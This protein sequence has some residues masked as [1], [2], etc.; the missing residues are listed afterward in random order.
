L[1]SSKEASTSALEKSGQLLQDRAISVTVAKPEL[2][3]EGIPVLAAAT[4]KASPEGYTGGS[5]GT[6]EGGAAATEH[7]FISNLPF[8]VEEAD[9]RSFFKDVRLVHWLKDKRG[10]FKGRAILLFSSKEASTSALEK[11]G[12]LLQDRAISVTVA[13]PELLKEGIPVLT[14]GSSS[15]SG[16]KISRRPEGTTHQQRHITARPEGCNVI[17]VSGVSKHIED[18]HMEDLF[19][20]CGEISEIRWIFDRNTGNFKQ[21]GCVEFINE[22]SVDLAMA[23][24]GEY[25]LGNPI[26]INYAK[27]KGR[28]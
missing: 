3:K 17:F 9:V 18:K 20:D 5:N 6:D 7:I 4:S 10:K 24:A 21:C 13:K 27:P 22:D 25:V 23:K 19:K 8:T 14:D 11:S 28:R 16:K 15:S 26:R 1:F 12:Q 2:L